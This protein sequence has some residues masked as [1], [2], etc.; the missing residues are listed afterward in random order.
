MLSV[1]NKL[2][3]KNWRHIIV[4]TILAIFMFYIDGQSVSLKTRLIGTCLVVL[5][6]MF[7]YYFEYLLI[8]PKFYKVN[9]FNLA[10]SLLGLLIIFQ[11]INHFI[12]FIV[13]PFLGD[14][15][16][17]E[18][19]PP[20]FL[21]LT[22]SFLFFFI[23]I[24]AFGATQNERSKF[25]LRIQCEREKALLVKEL[26]FFKNQFNPHITF[27]FLNYCY[28]HCQ[29]ESV[30]GGQAIELFSQML[31]YTLSSKADE[32]VPLQKEIEHI[33]N[34][35]AIQQILEKDIHVDFLVTGESQ[36]KYV[37]PRILINFV[38]NAFKHG[39][40]KC[41]NFPIRIEIK[42]S[43]DTIELIVKNKKRKHSKL[44][45]GVG[46]SNSLKQLELLY[47]GDYQYTNKNEEDFYS[48]EIQLINKTLVK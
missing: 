9:L 10:I 46:N 13:I 35:I 30:E 2:N 40:T 27:N 42:T 4:W 25:D 24:V 18:H 38:E 37:L 34:F 41:K 20:Y 26:G 31:R 16:G 3:E 48:C 22:T 43:N 14:P 32:P 17:F 44:S 23:S 28:S 5:G 19:D 12:F 8:F 47:K 33:S 11:L 15:N 7:V 6:Y 21:F 45:T 39:E 36:S 1:R 29:K